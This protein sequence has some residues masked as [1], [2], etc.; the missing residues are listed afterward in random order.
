VTKATKLLAQLGENCFVKDQTTSEGTRCNFACHVVFGWT[1]AAGCYHDLGAPRRILDR[2]LE[3][4]VVITDDGSPEALARAGLSAPIDML[5]GTASTIRQVVGAIA[6]T[7]A[8]A[9]AGGD[10]DNDD[11]GHAIAD[12]SDG[13]FSYSR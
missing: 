8:A 1:K 3:P 11:G 12:D 6:P 10:N 4:R 7:A 5:M 2:F 9:S 13:A